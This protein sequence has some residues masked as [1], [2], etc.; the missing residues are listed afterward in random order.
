LREKV[1][2]ASEIFD[3]RR[4]DAILRRVCYSIGHWQ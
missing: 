4:G 2:E 3:L 1:E